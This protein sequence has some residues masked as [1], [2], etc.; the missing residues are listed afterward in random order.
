MENDSKTKKA[1]LHSYDETLK[2]Q[3]S[4]FIGSGFVGII[5]KLSPTCTKWNTRA[6]TPHSSKPHTALAPHA[7]SRPWR[8]VLIHPP[9]QVVPLSTQCGISSSSIEITSLTLSLCSSEVQLHT[10][11]SAI[12]GIPGCTSRPSKSTDLVLD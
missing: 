11:K 1:R 2:L 3:A 12:D 8:S 6:F 5:S 10:I 4:M 9:S 7:S